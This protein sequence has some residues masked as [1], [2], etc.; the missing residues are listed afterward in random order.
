MDAGLAGDVFPLLQIVGEKG[1]EA[2]AD[3]GGEGGGD[4]AGG[5]GEGDGATAGD[6]PAKAVA[7]GGSST[8]LT[9]MRRGR[10]LP[11]RAIHLGGGGR[12]REPAPSRSV[13]RKPRSR[14]MVP[15]VRSVC[16]TAGATR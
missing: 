13:G 11:H 2:F 7:D 14:M 5:D 8:A 6:A 15:G 9:K 3:Q 12:Y 10:L 1:H 16:A 4:A